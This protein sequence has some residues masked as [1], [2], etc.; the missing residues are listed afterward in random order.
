MTPGLVPRDGPALSRRLRSTEILAKRPG[1]RTTRTRGFLSSQ[2]GDPCP[3]AGRMTS[4][5]ADR[6][7]GPP[8]QSADQ[9]PGFGGAAPRTSAIALPTELPVVGGGDMNKGPEAKAL[10]PPVSSSSLAVVRFCRSVAASV[11]RF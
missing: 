4:S 10:P 3:G 9:D 5:L 11:A 6:T 1:A 8:P 7:R 2:P